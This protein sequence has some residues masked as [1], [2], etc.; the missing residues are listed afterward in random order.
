MT[1]DE[2]F[3]E[4]M[5]LVQRRILNGCR[6]WIEPGAAPHTLEGAGKVFYFNAAIARRDGGVHEQVHEAAAC[7]CS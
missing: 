7:V 2:L 4:F 3:F 6:R 1:D 5:K